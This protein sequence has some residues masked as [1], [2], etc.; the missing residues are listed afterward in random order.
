VHL[1]ALEDGDMTRRQ[2]DIAKMQQLLGRPFMS[3]EDGIK[4]VLEAIH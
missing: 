4:K 3:L 1:P 2:P